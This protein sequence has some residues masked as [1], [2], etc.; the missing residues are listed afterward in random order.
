MNRLPSDEHAFRQLRPALGYA[1]RG[2]CPA[3]GH[4]RMFTRFLKPSSACEGCGQAWDVSRAD[5]LPAYLVILILGHI[6]VPLM[7][8]VNHALAIPIGMQAALWPSLALLLAMLM[9][10]PAKGA[11][12][13]FQWVRR[14]DGFA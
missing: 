9:I 11:V 6:L 14:L 3:C 4:G 10:Q 12:I 8:E 2:H 13:A 1:L 7:I 5:D